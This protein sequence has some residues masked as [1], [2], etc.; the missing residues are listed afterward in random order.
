[1]LGSEGWL[2]QSGKEVRRSSAKARC[3]GIQSQM[4]EHVCLKSL[5]DAEE[6]EKKKN[7][8]THSKSKSFLRGNLEQTDVDR[9]STSSCQGEET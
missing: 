4:M 1:M 3:H 9:Q 5:A 8:H 7:R 2:S 6:S